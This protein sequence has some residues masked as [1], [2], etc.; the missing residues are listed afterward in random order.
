[1]RVHFW[2]VRGSYPVPGP[3]TNEFGGNTS[4]V[5]VLPESGELL[6]VDAGTGIRKLGQHLVQGACASGCQV[7]LIMSHTHWDHLQGLPFF[8]PLHRPGNELVIYS[9]RRD[10]IHLRHIFEATARQPYF[11]ISF[12]EFRAKVRFVELPP[13]TQFAIGRLQVR[14]CPLNHPFDAMACRIEENGHAFVYASDTAPFERILLGKDFVAAPPAPGDISP[15]D[16]AILQR[17]RSDLVELC[18]GADLV[19]YDTHFTLEEYE[20]KP[21]WGHSAPEHALEIA[22]EAGA[23]TLCLFHHAPSHTD[24]QM[25]RILRHARRVAGG[26][27]QVIAAKEGMIVDL[28]A[29]DAASQVEGARE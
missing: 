28:A 13:K 4:C 18:R 26:R 21:H 12:K 5:Q 29:P 8:A 7:H 23:K 1:M 16:E 9:R 6:V 20:D 11:P 24:S 17:L 22:I 2:G 14:T 3:E 19:V 27:I 10:D 25:H 15:D